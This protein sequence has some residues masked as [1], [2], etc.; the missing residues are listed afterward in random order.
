MRCRVRVFSPDDLVLVKG[1]PAE[2]RRFLDDTL[3]ALHTKYDAIRLELDRIVSQRN[4]LLKQAGGRLSDEVARSR[5]TCGTPSSP[6]SASRSARPAPTLVARL[7]PMV[8]RGLR[9]TR[10][11]ADAGRPAATSRRGERSASPTALA[12]VRADD[13]RRGVIAPSGPHRDELRAV[14]Q[15]PAGPHPRVAGRAADAGPGPAA[16]RAP[17]GRPNASASRRCSC[18]TTCCPSS[19]RAGDALLAHLPAGQVVITTAGASAAGGQA[20]A[21]AASRCRYGRRERDPV[22]R[23]VGR[24]DRARSD[25]R[26]RS[27]AIVG[28]LARRPDRI[29]EVGGVFGRWDEAVGPA[30]AAHVRPV[31]ARRRRADRGGRRP[32]HGRRRC[33]FLERHLI[34]PAA[35][36]SPACDDRACRGAGSAPG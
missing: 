26:G 21:R 35:P 12:A 13:V 5:S 27:T 14:R 9:A 6:R 25:L 16:G 29:A 23:C 36:R 17:A 2:R 3:V 24:R 4:T 28:S 11:A 18:S 31:L 19:T 33:K 10:R 7:G 1:G 32:G 8:A 22:D 20:D 34:D 15:R 30:V